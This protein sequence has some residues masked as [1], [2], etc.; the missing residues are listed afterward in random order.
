LIKLD[1]KDPAIVVV[2]EYLEQKQLYW[3]HVLYMLEWYVY[4]AEPDAKKLENTLTT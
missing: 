4:N 2:E 3:G 1:Q